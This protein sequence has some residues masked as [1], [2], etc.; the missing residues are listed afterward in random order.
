[1]TPPLR[2]ATGFTGRIRI[3]ELLC[4]FNLNDLAKQAA[5][6]QWRDNLKDLF[7]G[8]SMLKMSEKFRAER[9]SLDLLLDHSPDS[10]RKWSSAKQIFARRSLRIRE[11][12][13]R[14]QSIAAEGKLAAS[15]TE[16][17]WSYAHLHVNRLF[18][19]A[20]R[21]HEL[22]LYDFLVRLYQSRMTRGRV[23]KPHIGTLPEDQI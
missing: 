9:R 13:Q 10:V 21:A 15:L 12:T 11:A 4:D 8:D 17:A 6:R 20:H 5:V 18:R 2:S 16:L 22:V 23:L 1:V 19:S 7:Q 3:H 14:L